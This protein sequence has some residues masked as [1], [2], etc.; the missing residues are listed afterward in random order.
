[1]IAPLL[2]LLETPLGPTP[3]GF[4]P[5]LGLLILRVAAGG[6]M[7]LFHGISKAESFG[8]LKTS[9]PDPLGVGSTASLALVVFAEVLCA[10]LLILGFFTRLAAVPLIVTM[11][12][13]VFVQQGND[14]WADRELP[15]LFLAAFTAVF[16]LGAGR[17]SLDSAILT[18]SPRA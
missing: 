16:F 8:T 13:A 5:N 4:A 1:M 15:M 10:G 3:L 6:S 7:L 11:A 9:F 12:V 14:P 17:A 18:R 2:R